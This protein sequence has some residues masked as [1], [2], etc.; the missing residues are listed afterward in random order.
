MQLFEGAKRV[1]QNRYDLTV[2][3]NSWVGRPKPRARWFSML[4]AGR[5]RS[6]ARWKSSRSG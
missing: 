2:A 6:G 5:K 3:D 1:S 4:G